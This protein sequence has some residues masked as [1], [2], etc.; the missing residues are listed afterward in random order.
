ML[1]K[2]R[3]FSGNANRDLA[4][5]ICEKLGV[6]LG[7]A[8]VSTFSDGETRVEINENVRGM[9]VFIIQSTCPPVNVT[10]MEL[11]IM[12]DAMKRASA[13]RITAVM[14]YY[15]YARQDRKVA[16]RA[17]ISAKLVADLITTAGANRVLSM[18]LHAGQIQGFF[19]IPVDNLFATPV[20]LDY[21]KKHYSDNT[22][23]VSP[24]TGGVVRARAFAT[25]L[26]ASLAIIDK[27]REGPN[28]AQVMN[29]IGDVKGKTVII[30]DDMIDTAG[31]V[32]QAADALKE[33]G[34]L[35]VSV[36]CTHPVLSGPAI[37]RLEASDIKEVIVTDTIPLHERAKAC[38]LIKVLSVSSL[39]SE[40]VRRIYYDDSVS[41]LFI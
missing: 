22:V 2:I 35:G 10:L 18:D 20:L 30:L 31:T 23:I 5:K 36:C 21:I 34:A 4:L 15:G 38:N 40:A 29:I 1:E 12:I 39:L 37:D 7:K 11:L 41:S 13:Y 19:N 14:P 17:P 27:R 32:V 25:R 26:G 9:D 3:I 33:A 16:P 28:E 8:N 6:P 24:D